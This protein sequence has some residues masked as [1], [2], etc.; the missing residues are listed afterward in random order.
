MK[1]FEMLSV[2]TGFVGLGIEDVMM[3]G[4]KDRVDGM[5]G[6][7]I[8]DLKF[9]HF[10]GTLHDPVHLFWRLRE[11]GALADGC[12]LV[13]SDM[14]DENY[15]HWHDLKDVYGGTKFGNVFLMV[16]RKNTKPG[17]CPSQRG[18]YML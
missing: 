11:M 9:I 7:K 8:R 10:F 16:Y 18:M 5:E 2:L 17:I 6:T 15:I 1:L 4:G 13:I 12:Y 14:D 3:V